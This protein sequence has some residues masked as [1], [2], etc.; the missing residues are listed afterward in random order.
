MLI[1]LAIID[2]KWLCGRENQVVNVYLYIYVFTDC[3]GINGA[4]KGSVHSNPSDIE[5][6]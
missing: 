2:E 3:L 4:L 1:M 5:R 6:E